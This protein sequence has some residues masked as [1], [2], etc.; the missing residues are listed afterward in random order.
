MSYLVFLFFFFLMIRRPPRSTLF[1]YTT[2]FRSRAGEGRSRGGEE[3]RGRGGR[4]GQ[5]ESSGG[6]RGE[7]GQ[8]GIQREGHWRR[9][10]DE[11]LKN[12]MIYESHHPG[13]GC[14]QT[15]RGGHRESTQV[16]AR[17]RRA[18]PAGP[19]SRCVARSRGEERGPRRGASAGT[20]PGRGR[21]ELSRP[22]DSVC[23]QRSVPPG[24]SLFAVAGSRE[25]RRRPADHGL[26]CAVPGLV[27]EAAGHVPPSERPVG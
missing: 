19:V 22:G 7:S 23:G 24:Q 20:D 13:S 3:G 12:E 2:L 17:V 9:G 10:E 25:L 26:R 15:H 4:R 21:G 1:P 16:P 8:Q 5:G 27:P 14:R 6:T 18:I 11:S